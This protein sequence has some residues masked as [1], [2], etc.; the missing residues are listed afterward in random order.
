MNIPVQAQKVL[1]MLN[2]AGY[3]AWLVGGSVRD[4]IMG[5]PM[6]DTDITT[7][8]LPQQTMEVFAGYRVIE[9]GL[10]HGTVTVVLDHHHT[11]ITTYRTDSTYSDS[12]HPDSVSFTASLREDCAR[13]DFT[14]NAVCYNPDYG[15]VDYYGG[16]E[17]IRNKII[18][19]VGDP[20]ARFREDALRILRAVRFASVL[21]FEIEENTKKAVFDCAHLLKNISAERIY[22]ELLKLL[23]G[24]NVKQVLLDYADVLGVFM[25]EILPL[26][27]FDQRNYHH[28]YDVLEHTAVAVQAAPA[29]PQLRLAALLHD[30][31]KPAVFSVD[32][33]G[34]GHFYGHGEVS[35][36]IAKAILRRLKVSNE[37]YRL[38]ST[39]VR[40]HDTHIEHTEKAVRRRLNR[41]G[42][43]TLRLLMQLKRADNRGQNIRDF[44]RTA[45]YDRLERLIAREIEKQS[46][47]SLKQLAV[48]GTDLMAIGLPRSSQLGRILNALLE[49]VI[50]GDLPNEKEILLAE[51]G[52]LYSAGE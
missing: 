39:L 37:E 41:Y 49:M 36:D 13:R 30:F 17:D 46:C 42:P 19:C 16:A 31:G 48:N 28:I 20:S 32:E 35:Y 23:C 21:G 10:K 22:T 47:F 18:R 2:S 40:Y 25:P 51:A 50:N 52:R 24:K 4:G 44:D 12:R 43:D 29:H 6:G 33:K 34:V 45:E 5:L 8:A 7:N 9:T 1:K 27:G 26:K 14:M 38:V 3:E 15:I 11:E